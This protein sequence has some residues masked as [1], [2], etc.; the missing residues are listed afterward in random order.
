LSRSSTGNGTKEKAQDRHLIVDKGKNDTA[1]TID[2]KIV[3]TQKIVTAVTKIITAEA[4]NDHR[5]TS[6]QSDPVFAFLR[7]KRNSRGHLSSSDS[8]EHPL[9]H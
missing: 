9:W 3:T 2:H 8:R 1:R 4:K 7:E 5:M 6:F